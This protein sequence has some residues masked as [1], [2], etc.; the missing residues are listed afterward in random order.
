M[1]RRGRAGGM[2]P[3][4]AQPQPHQNNAHRDKLN[5]AGIGNITRI[6]QRIITRSSFSCF[7]PEVFLKGE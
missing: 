6:L 5:V 3:Y 1:N 7:P 4:P 2:A